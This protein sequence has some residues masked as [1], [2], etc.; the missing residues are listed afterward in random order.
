MI[1]GPRTIHLGGVGKSSMKVDLGV[2]N[3]L[4]DEVSTFQLTE[5]FDFIYID[6]EHGYRSINDLLTTLRFYNAKQVNYSVRVRS[7]NDPLIQTLLDA[8]VRNFVLPQIRSIHDLHYFE[9]KVLFPPL[10]VRGIHP[11]ST[12]K[13]NSAI[14][15][16]VSLTVIIET[17]QALEILDDLARIQIVSDFYIGVFDLAMELGVQSGPFSPELDK[18]F[19]KVSDACKKYDKNFVAMLSN[20]DNLSV[21]EKHLL[22]KVVVGVD[23]IL[24][25]SFYLDLVERLRNNLNG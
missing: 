19:T 8:G 18:Y 23:S 21:I 13:V 4:P 3:V 25:H 12:L 10:G 5:Y 17:P 2:W 1:G 9:S 15:E 16:D 22:D 20:I 11:K 6:L 24:T 7:F 14:S